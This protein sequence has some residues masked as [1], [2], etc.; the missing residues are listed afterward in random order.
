MVSADRGS[1][2]MAAM[3]KPTTHTA[4][5]AGRKDHFIRRTT[6]DGREKVLFPPCAFT[7]WPEG[8]VTFASR[9]CNGGE[10]VPRKIKKWIRKQMGWGRYR[11]WW[12]NHATRAR[13][14]LPE[15]MLR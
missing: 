2:H 11:P 13:Q 3:S 15:G 7:Y 12:T 8:D 6:P 10:R 14:P 1:V 4:V 5:R 9:G